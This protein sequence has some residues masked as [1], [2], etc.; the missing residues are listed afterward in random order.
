MWDCVFCGNEF[1]EDKN[2]SFYSRLMHKD[3]SRNFFP[4]CDE[5]FSSEWNKLYTTFGS[6]Y[7]I[8]LLHQDYV[9]DRLFESRG[10]KTIK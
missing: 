8:I 1:D 2:G 4:V 5:C 3:R 10:F 6:V 7:E 9:Y